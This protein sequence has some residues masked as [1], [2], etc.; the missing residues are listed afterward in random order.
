MNDLFLGVGVGIE[1]ALYDLLLLDRLGDNLGN[2]LR[3]YLEITN[4]LRVNNDNGA[5]LTN[6]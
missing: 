4:F 6:P 1:Q 3:L 5:P 2:I